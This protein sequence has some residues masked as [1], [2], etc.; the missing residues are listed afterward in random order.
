MSIKF[1][2]SCGKPLRARDEMAARRSI[3]PR[4]GAPVGI[5]SLRPTHAG[6][7]AAPLT[8][9]ERRRSRRDKPPHGDDTA[10]D[11]FAIT[12]TVPPWDPFISPAVPPV[13]TT[14]VPPWSPFA[15][16]SAPPGK[17]RPRRRPRP[18]QLETH[19]SQC[20][21]YPWLCRRLLAAFT[22]ALTLLSGATALLLPQMPG[23]PELSW[24][25]LYWLSPFLLMALLILPCACGTVVC[26]LT[27]ALAGQG[28]GVYWPGRHIVSA[29]AACLRWLV[30]FLAGPV[31]P[32]TLAGY[33]WLWGG[34]L[35][36]LDWAILAELCVLA[37]A[38]W[39]LAVVQSTESGRL[40]DANPLRIAQL[41]QRLRYRAAV[42]VLVAPAL[43]LAHGLVA[44]FSLAE[45]HRF[46]LG[47]WLLLAC[48]WGSGLFWA[49]FLFRLL[50]VWCY[51]PPASVE[52]QG[53]VTG[54]G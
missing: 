39:L 37:I 16:P 19:W 21:A 31:V 7:D 9:Q 13:V 23:W 1:Y 51:R 48:C 32:A 27:S 49:T 17:Q 4:C 18:R 8:P 43:V 52:N 30:C 14:T 50:G 44:L 47:G 45:L 42:P 41:V 34:D 25:T 38:Y 53:P 3:C 35:T 11:L 29:L 54:L 10:D 12:I 40:R 6:T 22:L 24:N 15:T 46:T 26:A 28:P 36:G 2:C 20:L 33:F 5:P